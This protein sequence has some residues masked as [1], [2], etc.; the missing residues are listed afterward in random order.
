MKRILSA[1][2][3]VAA[4]VAAGAAS[5]EES[6]LNVTGN[7]SKQCGLGNQSG[8]G[9]GGKTQPVNLGSIVD[10][11]G[12]LSVAPQTIGFG[13]VWCNAPATISLAVSALQNTSTAPFDSSSFVNKLDMIVEKPT[14]GG[15]IFSYFAPGTTSAR[16]GTAPITNNIAG[17]FETGTLAYQG[18]VLKVALPT[19]TQGNDRPTAGDYA[20]T[21]TLTVTPSA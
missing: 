1:A 15:S 3:A 6:Q 8:G 14:S 13:N 5:A 9:T 20:G 18:A 4:L 10:G 19:G 17:A 21:V 16:T 11:N 2:V 7:V 12:Q